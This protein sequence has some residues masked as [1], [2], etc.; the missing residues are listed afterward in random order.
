MLDLVKTSYKLTINVSSYL[1]GCI[2]NP[3]DYTYN[4]GALEKLCRNKF[5]HLPRP[6]LFSYALI[7]KKCISAAAMIKKFI[8][9]LHQI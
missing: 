9:H 6:G 7:V 1:Q 5:Y 4:M 8:R 3:V 2:Q